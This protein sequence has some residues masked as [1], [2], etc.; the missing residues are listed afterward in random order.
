MVHCKSFLYCGYC[1]VAQN[2][3]GGRYVQY[4][5]WFVAC[6]RYVPALP[7]FA[8]AF[9]VVAG[10]SYRVAFR[11]YLVAPVAD[12]YSPVVFAAGGWY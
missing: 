6:C 7:G 10:C 2:I 8:V 11:Y 4:E 12:G 5:G 9:V 1:F 3:V